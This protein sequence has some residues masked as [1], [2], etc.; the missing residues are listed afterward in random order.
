[1]TVSGLKTT[2]RS[3]ARDAQRRLIL[4]VLEAT[5]GNVTRSAERL[6]LS[7]RG[8]QIKMKEYGLRDAS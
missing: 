1:M 3:V 2:T 8:L 6:G 4:A 7:R 5:G